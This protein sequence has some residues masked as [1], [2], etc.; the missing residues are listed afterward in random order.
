MKALTKRYFQIIIKSK[1]SLESLDNVAIVIEVLEP[2]KHLAECIVCFSD[3]PEA[4]ISRPWS[5]CSAW[6]IGW[7]FYDCLHFP[8][9]KYLRTTNIICNNDGDSMVFLL[10][11]KITQV[12]TR[13]YIFVSPCPKDNQQVDSYQY[14]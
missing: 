2:F 14:K 6:M 4:L 8:I 9:L 7:L 11:L 3:P 1:Y 10:M 13:T 5:L 12:T